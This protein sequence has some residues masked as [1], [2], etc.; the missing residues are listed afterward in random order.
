MKTS[1]TR[2]DFLRLSTLALGNL[3][4][5]PL[6]YL[7]N[8]DFNPIGVVR[9]TVSRTDIFKEPYVNSPIIGM[10]ERD[11]LVPIFEEIIDPEALSNSPRW[12]RI[13]NGFLNSMYT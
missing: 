6:S 4:F 9:V 12:Y 8:G 7:E 2:R 13:R 11:K 10:F 1:F 5:R 3:A